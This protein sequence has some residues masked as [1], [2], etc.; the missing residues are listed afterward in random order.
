MIRVVEKFLAGL[1]HFLTLKKVEFSITDKAK[2]WLA[3]EG[4]DPKFG[5]RPLDRLIQDT[6]KDPLAEEILS[7]RLKNGGKVRV[8]ISGSRLAFSFPTT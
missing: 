5:A 3:R 1:D 8:K 6:I 7:G 2:A 4:Y